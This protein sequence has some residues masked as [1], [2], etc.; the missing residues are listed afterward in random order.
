MSETADQ[1]QSERLSA[2]IDGELSSSEQDLLSRKLAVDAALRRQLGRYQ[3][4]SAHIQRDLQQQQVDAT[5]VAEAVSRRLAE[6]PTV[7]APRR[8]GIQV[9]RI[10][11]GA[12]LAATVAAVA[13]GVAPGL[14]DQG[15]EVMQPQT[16]AFAPRLSVPSFPAATVAFGDT[17]TVANRLNE[18]DERWK[19]LQ[20]EMQKKLDGYL[21]EH[22][23]YAA[24]LGVTSANA[25]VG[26]ISTDAAR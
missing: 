12:A 13:V 4:V 22:S 21:L 5:G 26:F 9:P 17:A 15:E 11:L 1:Q 23:E 19:V 14:L 7:L 6:E 3:R 16:F 18:T 24:R 20:P 2:F 25:H 10:A 8:K